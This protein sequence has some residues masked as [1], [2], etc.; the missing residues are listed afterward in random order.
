MDI[1]IKENLTL[2]IHGFGGTVVNKAFV[3]T[4][5]KLMNKMWEIVKGNKIA[6]KGLNVW[7]YEGSTKL[8]AGVELEETPPANTGVEF[9]NIELAKYAYYKHVGPYQHIGRSGDRVVAELKERGIATTNV[10]IEIY[11]HWDNDE[12][13]LETELIW[14]VR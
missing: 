4:A 6:N 8:F 9:K 13:K 11:G 5:F 14:E 12:S 2:N 10:Y 1:E 7:V 3:D